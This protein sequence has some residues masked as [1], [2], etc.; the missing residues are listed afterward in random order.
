MGILDLFWALMAQRVVLKFLKLPI[1]LLLLRNDDKE[2]EAEGSE[3]ATGKCRRVV[4]MIW[5]F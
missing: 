1:V 3:E 4:A 5:F 2:V